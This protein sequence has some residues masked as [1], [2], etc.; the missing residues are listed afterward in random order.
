[1]A[2]AITVEALLVPPTAKHTVALGQLT[3]FNGVLVPDGADFDVQV[4]PPLAV[5]MIV[6]ELPTSPP[7][8]TQFDALAHDTPWSPAVTPV[9]G[10]CAV[11]VDPPLVVAAISGNPCATLP[12]ATQSL[13]F[14]QSMSLYCVVALLGGVCAVHVGLLAA[15]F[16][17]WMI[18]PADEVPPTAQQL[19]PFGHV[20]P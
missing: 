4:E 3:S 14:T 13:L 20:T 18:L 10:V 16:E 15:A 1:M 5:A 6:G 11:Q 8:A 19:F 12:T 9:G 17:V 7:T 2:V